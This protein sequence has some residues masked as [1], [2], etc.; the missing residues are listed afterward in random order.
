MSMKEFFSLVPKLIRDYPLA[1]VLPAYKPDYLHEALISLSEQTDLRFNLY[2]FDDASPSNLRLI[3]QQHTDKLNLFYYRFESNLGSSSLASHWNR[4]ILKTTEDWIWLFSDDDIASST[5]VADFYSNKDLCCNSLFS[6]TSALIY[7]NNT[8]RYPS[9]SVPRF[10]MPIDRLYQRLNHRRTSNAVDHVFSRAAFDRQGGFPDLPLAWGSDDLAW[11]IFSE[12]RP[13]VNLSS[14]VYWR[15]SSQSISCSNSQGYRLQKYKASLIFYN[16]ICRFIL[17]SIL[18]DLKFQALF[19]RALQ[20]FCLIQCIHNSSLS[21]F[22]L[23]SGTLSR[24]LGVNLIDIFYLFI[25]VRTKLF[26]ARVFSL[27]S[28]L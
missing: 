1:V 11:Y 12:G 26:I 21:H 17:P 13:C 25:S 6:F 3:S 7:E 23:N 10:E 8:V 2:I 15:L 22:V 24:S 20:R 19:H 5:C 18:F 16:Y 9:V 27:L 28:N 14:Y 4:C